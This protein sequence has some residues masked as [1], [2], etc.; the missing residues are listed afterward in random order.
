MSE[1]NANALSFKEI[2]FDE[3]CAIAF[4]C[5]MQSMHKQQKYMYLCVRI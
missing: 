1:I 5:D 4:A 3:G 2:S